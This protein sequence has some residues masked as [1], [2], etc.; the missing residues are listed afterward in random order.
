[1]WI[2]YKVVLLF[3]TLGFTFSG[4]AR[5]IQF[6]LT[7]NPTTF[8]WNQIHASAMGPILMNIMEGL[9]QERQDLKIEPRL[10]ESYQL[11]SDQ[12]TYTFKIK[13]VSWSDGK[14]LLAQHFADSWERLLHPKTKSGYATFLF[15]IVGAKDF[16]LGKKSFSE[17][18]IKVLSKDKIQIKLS[19]PIP[20]FLH[21]LTFWVTFPIRKDLIIQNNKKWSLPPHLVTLGPYKI[22]NWIPHEFILFEKN[23]NYHDKKR[24]ISS[25]EKIRG[26]IVI[27]E[28]I[29]RTRFF[30]GKDDFLINA[31]TEDFIRFRKHKK[32]KIRRYPYLATFY[33]GFQ[34]K[35]KFI[36][37]ND[38][39]KAIAYSIDKNELPGILKGGQTP[40]T[41]L[42]PPGL[43]GHQNKPVIIPSIIQ[44][45]GHLLKSGYPE[46]KGISPLTL[47]IE[48]FDGSKNLAK[49]LEKR[50]LKNLGIR[51]ETRIG[52]RSQFQNARKKGLTDLFI[53]HWGADYPDP[54]SFFNVFLS[55]SGTNYT[56]WKNSFYDELIE[57][58][59]STKNK[60]ERLKIYGQA[61]E[62]LLQ[63]EVIITP[64][65]HKKTTVLIGERIKNL[66]LTPL[67]YL[68]FELIKLKKNN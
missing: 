42:I 15:D 52:S 59:R 14:P 6:R 29:A 50:F 10:V 55:K 35:R 12:K 37:N 36:K 33:L 60:E 62:L 19:E 27:N 1:M 54:A 65:F 44:A 56:G 30:E 24:L 51:I 41:G 18:G 16:H 34:T 3:I 8:D 40:A 63:K 61:E 66:V 57:K 31:T 13:N 48:N 68:Y 53:G 23:E 43:I 5:P 25:P 46:G 21:I 28:K 47:W 11:S 4:F 9:F 22:T 58:A 32:I 64:L 45:K 38:L 7:M 67:N 17:V 39:R 49:F 2:N 20:Y 26:N